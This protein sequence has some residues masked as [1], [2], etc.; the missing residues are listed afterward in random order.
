[1]AVTSNGP[2]SSTGSSSTCQMTLPNEPAS[3]V[4]L[5]YQTRLKQTNFRRRMTQRLGRPFVRSLHLQCPL[6]SPK[7]APASALAAAP[8]GQHSRKRIGN[9]LKERFNPF[10]LW[11]PSCSK[12]FTTLSLN[13]QDKDGDQR[14]QKQHYSVDRSKIR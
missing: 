2:S 5:L 3:C 4:S 9:P 11:V 13:S 1:V 6:R 7:S 12:I 14:Q 8:C 10:I